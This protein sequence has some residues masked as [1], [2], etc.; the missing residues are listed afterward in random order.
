MADDKHPTHVIKAGDIKVTVL[1]D[2]EAAD[3]HRR[4]HHRS[5]RSDTSKR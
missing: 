5:R 4:K 3:T 1:K 2:V